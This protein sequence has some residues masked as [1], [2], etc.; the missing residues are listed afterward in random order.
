[1]HVIIRADAGPLIGGGHV[2]RC[3]SLADCLAERGAR[4]TFACADL[5][6]FLEKRVR[7]S[8]HGLV[9][10]RSPLTGVGAA[11][12]GPAAAAAQERD[13]SACLAAAGTAD[14][15]IVDHYGLDCV[16]EQRSRSA[17]LHVLTFDDLA[18]RAHDCDILLDQTFGRAAADYAELVPPASRILAGAIYAPVRDEFAALRDAALARRA[19]VPAQRLLVTLGSTDLGGITGLVLAQMVAS[20][21][22]LAIDVAISGGAPS[23]AA[24]KEMANANPR[25]R[26]HV[27]SEAIAR[28]MSVADISIGAAGSTSWER[29]CLGLPSLVFILADNQ[30]LIGEQLENAGAHRLVELRNV[31][32]A[33]AETCRDGPRLLDMS[34]RASQVTDGYGAQR[35]R[36]AMI[37]R[38]SR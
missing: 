1:M 3:L 37:E 5:T 13:C 28:L 11:G 6:P 14:W 8:G 38:G 9:R 20:G 21:V 19:A 22:E 2:M 35:V 7:Q 29:C 15:I 25:I 34:R 16:W 32:V 24:C 33:L 36:D 26:L 10:F 12:G 18:N 31:S 27:D 23:L 30:R 17:T 4:C